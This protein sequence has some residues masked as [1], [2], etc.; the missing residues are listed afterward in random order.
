VLTVT[1]QPQIDKVQLRDNIVRELLLQF[2]FVTMVA[3]DELYVYE[4][5]IYKANGRPE[6]I[7]KEA[8]EKTLGK[9]CTAYDVNEN[10][11]RIK[12]LTLMP[13]T[14]F[15]SVPKNLI[16]L[17][18]CVV[19]FEKNALLSFNKDLHFLSKVQVH[20]RP[21]ETCP[22]IAKFL[23]EVLES[24]NDV[25]AI[26]EF[27]GYCLYRDYPIHTAFMFKGGGSN[28]KSTLLEMIKRFLG[29]ENV[30]NIS[31]QDLANRFAIAELRGKMANF[32]A[33]LKD[34]ALT[35]TGN[36][37]MLTGN[38]SFS[39]ERKFVQR[40]MSFRNLAKFA[41][42]CNKIPENKDDDTLAFWRRWIIFDFSNVFE[43]ED[44]DRHKLEKLCTETEF[45]GLLNRALEGLQRLLKKGKFSNDVGSL[46]T[47]TLWQ[48]SDSV[49][50]FIEE[51][52]E[53]DLS[54]FVTK[55]KCYSEYLKYCLENS[56]TPL[57][58]KR[59]GRKLINSV[60]VR[61]GKHTVNGVLTTCYIGIKLK[62]QTEEGQSQFGDSNV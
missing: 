35:S 21:S 24:E 6:Q 61:D 14:F 39:A 47:R 33:D 3:T 60:N 23:H 12:R 49:K 57:D 31:L 52:L 17:A 5:G 13:D 58:Q 15:D 25:L 45:S 30:S 10:I 59:F 29:P 22:E 18:D 48:K 19:D 54:G 37:K 41:F 38:D 40:R 27:I 1:E 51:K 28:G 7:I 34:E 50:T 2:I 46:M 42:S 26:Y 8:T 53:T 11:A 36:F 55:A 20:Y 9:D 62:G 43:G 16:P 44:C 4:H 32:Y 56:V